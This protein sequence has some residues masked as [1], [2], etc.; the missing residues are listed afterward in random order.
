ME[1]ILPGSTTQ[2][3][4][5]KRAPFLINKALSS[6]IMD[7][8]SAIES[9][10]NLSIETPSPSMRQSNSLTDLAQYAGH[11]TKSD[12]GPSSSLTKYSLRGM[13]VYK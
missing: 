2:P 6:T 13:C 3:S 4:I 12:L 10:H 8:H 9:Q 11:N 5:K 1:A 7:F